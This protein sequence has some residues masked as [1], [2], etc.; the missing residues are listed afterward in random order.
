LTVEDKNKVKS[1]GEEPNLN[2]PQT[3]D[4]AIN[5]SDADEWIK[6]VDF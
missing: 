2:E 6:A 4:E 1:K 3:Y 5:A